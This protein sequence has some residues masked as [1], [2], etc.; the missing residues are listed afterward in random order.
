MSISS[1][2]SL[3]HFASTARFDPSKARRKLGWHHTVGFEELARL[4][5]EADLAMLA[6]RKAGVLTPAPMAP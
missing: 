4:M 6:A 2:G 5:V 1:A 3:P